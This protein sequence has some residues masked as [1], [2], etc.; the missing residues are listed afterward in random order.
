MII[1]YVLNSY[2][3]FKNLEPN[4]DKGSILDYGSNWGLFLETSLGQIDHGLYTGIDVDLESIEHGRR[5]F[6]RANFVHYDAYNCMYNP[7][8]QKQLALPVTG[9]FDNIISYSVFTHTTEQDFLDRVKDLYSLL[10]KNGKMLISY[11]DIE[12]R[13]T[14]NF[15]Y[16]KRL[17][18]FRS[19]DRFDTSRN[20]TYL[21]DNKI[22]D[23]P[24]DD[25][26]LLT[27]YR[28]DY[29]SQI[30]KEYDVSFH[31]SI[32]QQNFQNCMII[33]K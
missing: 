14:T 24:Q 21:V 33:K 9:I 5:R 30:F 12:D 13:Y 6:P 31:K 26:L 3:F 23:Q 27:L 18:N 2:N 16:N 4:I 19:C 15:F 7:N 22:L 8:G 20:V 28:T 1:P 17:R 10:S 11:C 32:D 29:L 25:K